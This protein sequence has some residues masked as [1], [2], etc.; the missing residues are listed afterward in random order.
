MYADFDTSEPPFS[1]LTPDQRDKV[2]RGM[3]ILFIPAGHRIIEAGKVSSHFYI[4]DKGLVEER[5][6]APGE[7]G[8]TVA[9]YRDGE[10]FGSLAVLRGRARNTYVAA[11]DTL[12]HA[13]PGDLFREMV[14]AN[15]QFGEFFHQD[16]ATKTKLVAQSGAYRDLVS[17]NLARVDA[18]C[19]RTATA[20][21][22]RWKS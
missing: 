1:L 13:L 12:C 22:M 5:E 21:G 14:F 18:S 15:P 11:E 3:D 17:F 16:L 2:V 6:P 9:H 7:R 19:M 10:T 20:F 8:R 4:V